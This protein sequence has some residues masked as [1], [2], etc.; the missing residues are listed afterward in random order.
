MVILE[1]DEHLA[2][3]TRTVT[4]R[5]STAFPSRDGIP[6]VR[7]VRLAVKPSIAEGVS[8]VEQL[9]QNGAL[10]LDDD[11]P[12]RRY[13]WAPATTDG[14]TNAPTKPQYRSNVVILE[15]MDDEQEKTLSRDVVAL[16]ERKAW[17][18]R[19][20]PGSTRLFGPPASYVGSDHLTIL[21]EFVRLNWPIHTKFGETL[22]GDISILH[23]TFIADPDPYPGGT[24]LLPCHGICSANYGMTETKS[25][26][27]K[28]LFEMVKDSAY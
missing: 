7:A 28:P 22:L 6:R 24:S 11:V 27:G 15:L 2:K 10:L 12:D 9:I 16:A 8:D 26:K 5:S 3:P 25:I 19:L 21:E 23:Q 1:P 17:L 20:R 13:L 14:D 18:R 4:I